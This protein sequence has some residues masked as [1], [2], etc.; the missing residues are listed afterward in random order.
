MATLLASPSPNLYSNAVA[1]LMTV[2]AVTQVLRLPV[3]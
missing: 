1:K 2:K 3:L